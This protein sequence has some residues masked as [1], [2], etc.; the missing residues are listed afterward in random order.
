[1]LQEKDPVQDIKDN[2]KFIFRSFLNEIDIQAAKVRKVTRLN[3]HLVTSP[4]TNICK[5]RRAEEKLILIK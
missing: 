5:R 4:K 2:T 3:K 1:M